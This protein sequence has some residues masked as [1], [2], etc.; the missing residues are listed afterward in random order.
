MGGPGGGGPAVPGRI[1]AWELRGTTVR[2]AG[3]LAP[4]ATAV[5]RFVAT[6]LLSQLAG[7]HRWQAW[8]DFGGETWS[9]LPVPEWPD[10]DGRRPG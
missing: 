10:R 9:G 8:Y 1:Y 7:S 4:A 5:L 3:R 2:D 6:L